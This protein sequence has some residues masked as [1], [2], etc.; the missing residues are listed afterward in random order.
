ML[1]N[2]VS[3]CLY[4]HEMPSD[5]RMLEKLGLRDIPRWYREKFGVPS[6]LQASYGNNTRGQQSQAAINQPQHRAIQF[7]PTA[8]VGPSA[9]TGHSGHNNSGQSRLRG[10]RYKSPRGAGFA[11]S[12]KGRN[13]KNGEKTLGRKGVTPP[14]PS[15]SGH[16]SPGT[17]S[18]GLSNVPSSGD[19]PHLSPEISP[20]TQQ[21]VPASP[22]VSPIV[23][24]KGFFRTKSRFTFG[25]D[26]KKDEGNLAIKSSDPSAGLAQFNIRDEAIPPTARSPISK[27]VAVSEPIDPKEPLQTWG[28]VGVIRFKS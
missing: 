9:L 15:V 22:A 3:G 10:G 4:K 16:E 19:S 25:A 17:A 14:P 8:D 6:L 11:G 5:V 1:T 12:N 2:R 28:M 7:Q 13:H 27:L 20:R 18:V 21:S 23:K 24:S 26:S